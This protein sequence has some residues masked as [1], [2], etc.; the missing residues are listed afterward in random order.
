MLSVT[1]FIVLMLFHESKQQLRIV[2]DVAKTVLEFSTYCEKQIWWVTFVVEFEFLWVV[3]LRIH[4]HF[5]I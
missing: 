5:F 2:N 4:K 3:S 1:L